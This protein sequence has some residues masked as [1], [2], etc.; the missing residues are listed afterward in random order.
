MYTELLLTSLGGG[1]GGGYLG[2]SL[3]IDT[4]LIYVC[5]RWLKPSYLWI[6]V[7]GTAHI[8]D[9]AIS[10]NKKNKALKNLSLSS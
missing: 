4:L 8:L 1:G 3:N 9:M 10:E 5:A 6:T 2:S 7:L